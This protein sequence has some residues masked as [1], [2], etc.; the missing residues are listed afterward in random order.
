M[1]VSQVD[2][3]IQEIIGEVALTGVQSDDPLDS[4]AAPGASVSEASGPLKKNSVL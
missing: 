2:L 1:V 4:D 3:R